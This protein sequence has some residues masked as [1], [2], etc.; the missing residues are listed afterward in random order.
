MTRAALIL[1]MAIGSAPVIGGAAVVTHSIPSSN[2]AATTAGT[3]TIDSFSWAVGDAI[4]VAL[5][6]NYSSASGTWTLANVTGLTWTKQVDVQDAAGNTNRFV[7]WTA[8]AT[9]AGSGTL[10]ATGT[11]NKDIH[12]YQ[13]RKAT[14]TGG[15][16]SWGTPQ[17]SPA[18]TAT[19]VTLSGLTGVDANDY[20]IAFTSQMTS[21][22]SD[23]VGLAATPR[24]GW[25]NSQNNLQRAAVN[26][27]AFIHGQVSPVGGEA[28]ASV[29]GLISYGE[30]RLAV[31]PLTAT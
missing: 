11:T 17:T 26:W 27:C 15:T 14:I 7:I 8:I 19:S 21:N 25:A 13:V 10:T 31:I 9:A 29:T 18:T 20:Q 16:L 12:A 22:A 30:Y 2:Q 4:S 1:G 3:V 5:S 28:T 23:W 24:A 6:V